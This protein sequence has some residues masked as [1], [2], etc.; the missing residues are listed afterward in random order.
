M[1]EKDRRKTGPKKS[2]PPRTA[3]LLRINNDLKT[4]LVYLKTIRQ[5]TNLKVSLSDLV[6]EAIDMLLEVECIPAV[7]ELPQNREGVEL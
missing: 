2:V 4:R 6:N 3:D 7:N 1:N 5:E